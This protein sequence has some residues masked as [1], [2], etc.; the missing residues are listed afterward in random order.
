MTAPR[1]IRTCAICDGVGTVPDYNESTWQIVRRR[2]PCCKG[3]KAVDFSPH[4]EYPVNKG[5]RHP[6][7]AIALAIRCHAKYVAACE[8][9]GVEAVPRSTF[10]SWRHRVVMQKA[11]QG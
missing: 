6:S 3:A 4:V 1:R 9:A 7:H 11:R 5:E 2:C 10:Y 8:R